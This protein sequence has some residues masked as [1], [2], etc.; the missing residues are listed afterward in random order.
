MC[1]GICTLS[2]CSQLFLSLY[3]YRKAG[4]ADDLGGWESGQHIFLHFLSVL[5]CFHPFFSLQTSECLCLILKGNVK[6]NLIQ[7]MVMCHV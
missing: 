5:F 1:L 2:S 6:L 3:L 7:L 4:H